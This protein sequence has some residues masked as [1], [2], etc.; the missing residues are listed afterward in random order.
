MSQTVLL[1][2]I[3]GFIA[4]H[5]A[6]SLLN[7]G[8]TLRGTVRR[9]DRA[10][11]VRR[12]LSPHLDDAAMGRLS[13]VQVDLGADAGWDAA[14]QGVDILVHTASPFPMNQP[15]DADA[16]IRPAVDGT[17]RALRAAQA[18]GVRR[19]VLTS[20][21]VAI[22]PPEREGTFDETSWA[23]ASLPTTSPYAKSKIL[24]EQ[25]AWDFARANGMQLTTIN[26]G[27]VLGAPLGADFGTSV[28]LIQRI[29]KGR[30]PMLPMI[31]LAL[32]DVV[33]VATMHLRAVQDPATEGKRFA[34]VAGSMSMVD[35]ARLLKAA[36][37]TRR[38]ATRVAPALLL[39]VLALFDSALASILPSLNKPQFVSNHRAVT[40]MG[41]A[42][43]PP[44][45]A[46]KI[47]A[48]WLVERRL[49]WA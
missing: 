25:A 19:A 38:I 32:V 44:E 37:P 10:D 17:L 6:L 34:A 12:A 4:K 28:A 11:E 7:A 9:L 14:M 35:M 48:N 21:V 43:T 27:L 29:L 16:L 2:G 18:A 46:L 49:V 41:I 20:S 15:K 36:Y 26:P 30:D 42:F 8:Y 47:T 5:V 39:R 45:E 24:A 22:V 1:T 40:D 31:H 23:D 13:F 33:D 3:S